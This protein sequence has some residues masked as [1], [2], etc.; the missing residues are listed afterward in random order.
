M[1]DDYAG[2]VGIVGGVGSVEEA[3]RDTQ[4][5]QQAAKELPEDAPLS[6]VL[7]KAQKLKQEK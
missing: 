2:V 7:L 1:S 6:Q 4:F 5:Y 3:R